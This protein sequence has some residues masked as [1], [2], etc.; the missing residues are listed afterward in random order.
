MGGIFG[1]S[2]CCSL[3]VYRQAQCKAR[4]INGSI[5]GRVGGVAA[6]PFY[7]AHTAQDSSIG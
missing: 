3:F 1:V 4:V 5:K 7:R 6:P 2:L